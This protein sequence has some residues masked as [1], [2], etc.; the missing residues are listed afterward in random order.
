MLPNAPVATVLIVDDRIANRKLLESLLKPAGNLTLTAA[1]GEEAFASIAAQAPDLI[2]LDLKMPGI[3]GYQVARTIKGNPATSSIPIIMVTAHGGHYVRLAGLKAGAEEFLTTPV[4]QS[5][6]L[7]RVRNLLR[8]KAYGDILQNHS[9]VLEQQVEERT[10]SLRDS[11]ERFRQMAENIRDAFFLIGADDQQVLYISPA[12]ETIS[13][14]T[15]DS[16]R[17]D[18]RSWTDAIFPD[19]RERVVKDFS[20][21]MVSGQVDHECRIIRA[22]GAR[23]WVHVRGYPI[24]D[25]TGALARIAGIAVDITAAKE[26]ENEIRRLNETLEQRVAERTA[27]LATLNDDLQAFSSS[28]SHDLRAPLRHIMGFVEMITRNAVSPLSEQNS[29]YLA[30]ISASARYM[31]TLIGDLLEFSRV[32]RA[33]LRKRDVNLDNLVRE[34]MDDFQDE[35]KGRKVDWTIHPLPRVRADRALLRMV[36]VNLMSNAVKFTGPRAHARIEIG[37][38]SGGDDETVIF[39]RDNGAG[40]NPE[41]VEKLFGVFQRLHSKTEFPGTGIGLANVQ[42]ILQRHGGRAWAQGAVGDGA[43]FYFAIQK[44]GHNAARIPELSHSLQNTGLGNESIH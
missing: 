42:R 33:E 14:R 20:H 26:A 25:E 27:D 22:D 5:E 39:V 21:G 34:V 1:S 4:N 7:L 30:K 35:T 15:C 29:A 40:F 16:L 13:G 31:G 6:L 23:R 37:C 18:P 3:D 44:A 41:Y 38:F 32:G 19:D 9:V 11:D 8:L 28:V 12:Y 36:L 17:A 43:T 24:R 10:E 2:L